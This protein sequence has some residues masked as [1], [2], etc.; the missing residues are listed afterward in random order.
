[1]PA[2][3]VGVLADSAA[4]ARE[5]L[6]ADFRHKKSFIIPE[7]TFQTRVESVSDSLTVSS[8]NL[9]EKQTNFY[10]PANLSGAKDLYFFILILLS[11][12]YAYGTPVA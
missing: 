5:F 11:G 9:Y 10:M 1:V 8:K 7:K 3:R 6:L 4:D 2:D 12:I